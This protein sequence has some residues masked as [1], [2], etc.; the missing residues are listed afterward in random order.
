MK[1]L[2][3]QVRSLRWSLWTTWI[4]GG[5]LFLTLLLWVIVIQVEV[6]QLSSELS[7]PPQKIKDIVNGE[8]IFETTASIVAGQER[9]DS[10]AKH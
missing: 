7:P 5:L 10:P 1:T 3:E 6:G 2:E 8:I 9:N 4:N